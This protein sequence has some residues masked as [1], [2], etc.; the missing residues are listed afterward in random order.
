[1]SKIKIINVPTKEEAQ[2]KYD[3]FV[4]H[5]KLNNRRTALVMIATIISAILIAWSAW[6]YLNGVLRAVTE[7]VVCV[8]AAIIVHCCV[9]SFEPTTQRFWPAVCQYDKLTAGHRVLKA[10]A[11]TEYVGL[12]KMTDVCLTLADEKNEVSYGWICGLT[13][14]TKT[15]VHCVTVDLKE[16]KVYFP[17]DGDGEE[18]II[19]ANN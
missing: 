12:T 19:G 13:P 11:K 18:V 1:M 6:C 10:E 5:T 14:T 9:D 7:L 16:E 4:A 8:I 2:K 15:D 3:D 17:Y